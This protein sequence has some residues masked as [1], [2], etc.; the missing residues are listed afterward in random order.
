MTVCL[1][2]AH[3]V[4]RGVP[5]EPGIGESQSG[6]PGTVRPTCFGLAEPRFR[7]SGILLVECM[8]YLAV[9][10]VVVGLALATFYRAWDN[11]R[12]LTRYTEDMARA[13]KAGERWRAEIR[14]ATGALKLVSEPGIAD[15]ALHIPCASGEIVYFCTGTNLLRRAGEEG[16]WTV[17]LPAVK[18]SR[19]LLDARGSV[20]SWRWELELASSPKRQ[21]RLRPLFTFQAVPSPKA[22]P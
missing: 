20:T 3:G 15:H 17:L 12:S 14:Q 18:A 22:E 9:W 8:V 21:T 16:P 10:F 2:A 11:S 5:A 19:M 13:L 1:K 4:G 7:D 6:S